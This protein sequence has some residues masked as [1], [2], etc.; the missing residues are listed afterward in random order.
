M[1]LFQRQC[2][3]GTVSEAVLLGYCYR[4]SVTGILFQRQ[5]YCGTVSEAVL[6]GYCFRGSVTGVLL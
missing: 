1:V 5:C 4:D 6:L 2:Y 3:C